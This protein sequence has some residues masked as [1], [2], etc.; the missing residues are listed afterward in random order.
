MQIQLQDYFIQKLI[1]A[2]VKY[3][4]NLNNIANYIQC[5]NIVY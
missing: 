3:A 2:N 1:N 5:C 4:Y